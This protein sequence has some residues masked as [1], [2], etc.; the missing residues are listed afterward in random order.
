MGYRFGLTVCAVIAI[1]AAVSPAMPEGR[2]AS[3][4]APCTPAAM[5]AVDN[6]SV[7]PA[8]ATDEPRSFL[9]LSPGR[10]AEGLGLAAAPEAVA[11]L[12]LSSRRQRARSEGI[13]LAV[14]ASLFLLHCRF[15]I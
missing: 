3:C 9:P 1:A 15:I 12:S 5:R 2:A 14:N 7:F 10:R 11:G 4:A 8:L 6:A 13:L